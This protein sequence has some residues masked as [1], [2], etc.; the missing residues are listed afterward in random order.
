MAAP[1]QVEVPEFVG[2][3]LKKMMRGH[4]GTLQEITLRLSK[5]EYAKAAD[6]AEQGLGMSSVEMHFKKHVGKY[7]PKDMRAQNEGMHEAATRF[8]T[9]A[10]NAAKGDELDKALTSLSNV[11]KRCVSCHSAYRLRQNGK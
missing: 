10:R 9:D 1:R 8:A 5:H 4:L 7:M 2:K 11:I 3:H 6:I